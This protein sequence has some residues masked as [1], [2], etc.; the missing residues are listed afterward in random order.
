[1]PKLCM[2]KPND[3]SGEMIRI[4]SY[5]CFTDLHIQS[6]SSFAKWFLRDQNFSQF[7]SVS[8]GAKSRKILIII[9]FYMKELKENER[10]IYLCVW[11]EPEP[12]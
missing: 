3:F 7:Q 8:V 2:G 12:G 4:F 9:L 10:K 5:H 11:P 1:M 6:V